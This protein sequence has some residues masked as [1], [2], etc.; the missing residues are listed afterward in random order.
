M[1]IEKAE[2]LV[3]RGDFDA[4]V[5]GRPFLADP[6]VVN[7]AEAGG[8]QQKVVLAKWMLDGLKV[9]ILDEPTKGID[10]G[11][12]EDVFNAVD[13]LAEKGIGI[14]FISSDLDEV[15]RVSDKLLIMDGGRVIKE[16]KNENVTEAEILDIV[17]RSREAQKGAGK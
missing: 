16:M 9:L 13:S 11:A 6:D 1:N 10:I 8:N 5:M 4:I 12:K 15:F 2:E 7:K 17:L 14:I 3:D